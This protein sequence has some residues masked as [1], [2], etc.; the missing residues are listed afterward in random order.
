[1]DRRILSYIIAATAT[2]SIIAAPIDEAKKLYLNGN[3]SAAVREFK[4]LHQKS[5]KD[6]NVNYYLGASYFELGDYANAK[7][8][9]TVAENAGIADAAHLLAKIAINNYQLDAADTH[10]NKWSTLLRK[11]KHQAP[12]EYA[13]LQEQ[14]TTI[15]NMLERV[16]NIAVIDS[17]TVDAT[18]FF[19]HYNLSKDAGRIL[20]PEEM[21]VGN[22][23]IIY[24][25]AIG[26]EIIWAETGDD[27]KA[28]LMGAGILDDGSIEN[29]APLNDDLG[30][31]GNATYPFMLTD[32]M[33]LYFASDGEGSIGGYD[34]FM[35]RR[36]DNGFLQPQNIGMPY[37]SPD[38]DYLL[39]IDETRGIGWWATDRNHIP[40]KVTIYIF[41]QPEKRTNCDTD[42]EDDL[43]ARARITSI[44]ATQDPDKDYSELIALSRTATE[45][46][47]G[48]SSDSDNI[49]FRLSMG[50]GNTVYHKLSDF[51]NA[52]ARDHMT[53][54]LSLWS[55]INDT[56]THLASLRSSYAKG[57]RSVASEITSLESKLESQRNNEAQLSNT[58]I[59]LER[60]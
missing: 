49:T 54:L 3:Y 16:E 21:S 20:T 43:I 13:K 31:G 6:S 2:F 35:S 55:D 46:A 42:D 40:G 34:I 48:S 36:N 23:S 5:P 60:Y 53:E 58:I 38:N 18:D 19:K 25:P 12:A 39:A 52:Q 15:S 33:T 51:H 57:N 50:D 7:S 9:L 28:H 22:A 1:M 4:A 45:Q 59:R 8:P 41:E 27:G 56:E 11:G 47:S 37:N 29:A 17:M 30:N 24:T 26:K 14:I 44:A 32:G 10:L